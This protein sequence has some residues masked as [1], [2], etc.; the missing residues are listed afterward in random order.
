MPRTRLLH[1]SYTP[2]TRLLHASYTPLARLLHATYTPLTC[3]LH[4]SY[5]PQV[6]ARVLQ[7]AECHGDPRCSQAQVLTLLLGLLA[8]KYKY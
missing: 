2:L 3:L 8:Q 4:A 5:T 1:A 6:A 7:R